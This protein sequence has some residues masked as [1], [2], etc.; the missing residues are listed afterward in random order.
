MRLGLG[1]QPRDADVAQQMIIERPQLLAAA[2]ALAPQPEGVESLAQ[3]QTGA[4]VRTPLRPPAQVPWTPSSPTWAAV[5]RGRHVDQFV[6]C[7]D[8]HD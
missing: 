5:S 2:R 3:P 1:L 4:D 7:F 6:S 8:L